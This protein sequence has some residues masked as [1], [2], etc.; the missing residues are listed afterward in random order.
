MVET[1]IVLGNNICMTY[2]EN[3]FDYI[4]ILCRNI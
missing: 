3:T 2:V 4:D 1:Y